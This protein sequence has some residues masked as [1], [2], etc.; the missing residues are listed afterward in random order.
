MPA[1]T[2]SL[3]RLLSTMYLRCS[4]ERTRLTNPS[5][6]GPVLAVLESKI[7][8]ATTAQTVRSEK[9]SAREFVMSI[10]YGIAPFLET[11]F[12]VT[13]DQDRAPKFMKFRKALIAKL[14]EFHKAARSEYVG[15][16]SVAVQ[17]WIFSLGA[18]DPMQQWALTTATDSSKDL[19][20]VA[21]L[22]WSC[23]SKLWRQRWKRRQIS[24]LS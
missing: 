2:I 17:T 24:R 9:G 8:E 18:E 23:F 11:Y 19:A 12:T 15:G 22:A 6:F 10:V 7:E 3:T 1:V 4:F 21:D 13:L 20:S 5:S 16:E 14:Q